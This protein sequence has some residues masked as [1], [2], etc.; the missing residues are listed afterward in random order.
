VDRNRIRNIVDFY[1]TVF[2]ENFLLH[3]LFCL[4]MLGS[5]ILKGK[6]AAAAGNDLS[7]SR[8]DRENQVW[9][10]AESVGPR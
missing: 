10:T 5:L 4:G 2:L 1:F 7:L 8:G 6:E 9:Q 3:C